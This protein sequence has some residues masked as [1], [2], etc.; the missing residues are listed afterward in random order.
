MFK[1]FT[2]IFNSKNIIYFENANLAKCIQYCGKKKIKTFDIQHALSSDLNI[3]YKF[4]MKPK[5]S[6]LITKKIVLWGDYWK[7]FYSYNH[8]C[9]SL[10]HFD[11]NNV[12]NYKKKKQIFVVS[13][14]F[15]RADLIGLIKYI[16][17]NLKDY[18]IIYKLRP[19]ENFDEIKKIINFSTKNIIFMKNSYLTIIN[20]TIAESQYIIGTNSSMLVEALG[21]TD[22][23]LF[24]RGW[25]REYSEFINNKS[26]LSANTYDEVISI[27]KKKKKNIYSIKKIND[28]FKKNFNQNFKNFFKKE[29][30]D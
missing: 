23:I 18:K 2:K 22:I 7:R 20:K 15:S 5:Y 30:N 16:S 21:I 9:I 17:F 25:F 8:R 24:K 10:G 3:L 1:F 29:L 19:E 12:K 11:R 28:I 13:S 27:I 14:I 4:Y 26:F 6:Y